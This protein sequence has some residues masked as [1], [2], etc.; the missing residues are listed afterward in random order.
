MI[1]IA[2]KKQKIQR[3][4]NPESGRCDI[5]VFDIEQRS[6]SAV[7]IMEDAIDYL[8]MIHVDGRWLIGDSAIIPLAEPGAN[9]PGKSNRQAK[10]IEQKKT[11]KFCLKWRALLS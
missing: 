3:I 7:V 2:T 5:T 8:H 1:V 11:A 4:E 6:A 10:T 9:P